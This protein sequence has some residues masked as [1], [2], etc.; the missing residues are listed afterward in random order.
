M[1]KAALAVLLLAPPALADTVADELFSARAAYQAALKVQNGSSRRIA[2]L[3]SDIASA[4]RRI[5]QA[6]ADIE[7]MQ[8]E[9]QEETAKKAQADTALQAAGQRLDAAWQASRDARKP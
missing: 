2:S 6:Q 9:L 5:K 7:K 3:Q 8:G 1:K 4:Q